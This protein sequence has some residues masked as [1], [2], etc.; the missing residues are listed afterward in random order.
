MCC[1]CEMYV[2]MSNVYINLI[3]CFYQVCVH[4]CD[5]LFLSNMCIH[6][7]C[8]VTTYVTNNIYQIDQI[9]VY[10]FHVLLQHMLQT[11]TYI[12]LIFTYLIYQI[13]VYIFHVWLQH[14]L[15]TTY[16]KLIFTYL[17]ETTYVTN[18]TYQIDI[19]ILE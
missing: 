10:I 12:T 2:G 15:Q 16:I 9:C 8:V 18:N 1:S 13:C 6:L 7:S 17:I 19:H 14:M 11:T 3:C 4:Q 5:I